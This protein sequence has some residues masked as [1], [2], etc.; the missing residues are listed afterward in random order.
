M[1]NVNISLPE[2][3]KQYIEEQVANGGYGTTSEYVRELIREDKRRKAQ[4]EL[5]A[6]LLE[7]LESGDA[8]PVT[9]EFWNDL[10]SRVDSRKKARKAAAS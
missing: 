6:L 8:V 10:W 2:T 4:G 5:E 7:G 3:L 1:T 9:P